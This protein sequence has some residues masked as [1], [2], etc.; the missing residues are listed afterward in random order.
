M[1]QDFI[2]S[3]NNSFFET[4]FKASNKFFD[5]FFDL[6][7]SI[8][9]LISSLPFNKFIA[10][11]DISIGRTIV[12]NFNNCIIIASKSELPFLKLSPSFKTKLKL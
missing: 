10:V 3:N 6:K 11:L 8:T 2:I 9:F 4:M 5:R 7:N 12:F 1:G